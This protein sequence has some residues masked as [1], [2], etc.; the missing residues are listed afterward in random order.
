MAKQTE[1]LNGP[2][3]RFV[4]LDN[5]RFLLVVGVVLQHAGMAY[6]GSGWWPVTDDSSLIVV[7]LVGFF[8]GFL[9]PALFFISG[10]FAI[11][12]IRKRSIGAFIKG[13]FKR[14]G[15]PWLVCTLFIGPILPLIFHYTHNGLRLTRSYREIWISVMG[16]ALNPDIGILPPMQAVMQNDLFYQR[17]MWFIGVLIGF[18][19]MFAVIYRFRPAWFTVT[20]PHPATPS[21]IGSTLKLFL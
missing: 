13:K 17:Y 15:V 14:L 11:P 1:N 4:F 12:S 7:G 9:M 18:F 16:N 20:A 10:Y 6:N 19:L 21:G 5:L 3:Q 2:S 8:D